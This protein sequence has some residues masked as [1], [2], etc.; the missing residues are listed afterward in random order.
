[1]LFLKNDSLYVIPA[2]D[3]ST[4]YNF[5]TSGVTALTGF[6]TPTFLKSDTLYVVYDGNGNY[7][8]VSGGVT[9]VRETGSGD[10]LFLRTDGVVGALTSVR[11]GTW[12][13]VSSSVSKLA[14]AFDGA[15]IGLLRDTSVYS[16]VKTGAT[17][18][19]VTFVTSGVEDI[20]DAATTVE[21]LKE[22][23]W[24]PLP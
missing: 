16:A 11:N 3:R 2:P 22:G 18:Y 5:V 10:V 7:T 15:T 9:T 19:N 14:T 1:V 23:N 24:I 6:R 13:T 20:R 4:S 8:Y 12:T 21:Y 17:S